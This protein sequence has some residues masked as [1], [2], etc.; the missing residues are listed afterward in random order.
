MSHVH[1]GQSP[2][3]PLGDVEVTPEA[4]ETLLRAGQSADE[5]LRRFV[6]GEWGEIDEKDRRLNEVALIEGNALKG[7]YWTR[8]GDTIWII[9]EADRSNT[10]LM[11]PSQF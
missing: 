7:S 2:L 4:S 10:T 5:F 6:V 9:T 3:F 11:L 8:M 1:R